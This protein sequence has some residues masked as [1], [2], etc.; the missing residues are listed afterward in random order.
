[1]AA[2]PVRGAPTGGGLTMDL[3]P[4][5]LASE[6]KFRSVRRLGRV[7]S[8]ASRRAGRRHIPS[9]P[10]SFTVLTVSWNTL[11]YLQV[12]LEAVARYSSPDTRVIVV[13]NASTDGTREYLDALGVDAIVLPLN[14]GHGPAMDLATSRVDTEYF[15]T[16]DVDAFPV[17]AD[18][19]D[20]LRTELE[21]GATVVGGHMHRGFAHPSMLAMRTVDFRARDHTF[22]RSGWRTGAD[23]E[24]GTSWDVG[25][26][27][28][29]REGD[30]VTLVKPSEVRGPGPVGTVYGGIVYH[31]ALSSH[32]KPQNR[33]AARAAWQEARDR[34]LPPTGD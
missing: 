13:D 17:R 25:E 24:H 16:L 28:S 27:I 1:M 21:R 33:L 32:G 29:M 10:G 34:F 15:V 19:L 18:W 8:A 5:H 12:L 31:N 7:V 9:Q 6:A 20:V 23:F 30:R 4:K 26:L 11:E 14:L 3:S 22:L 2:L